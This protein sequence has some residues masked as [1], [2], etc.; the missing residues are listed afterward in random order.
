MECANRLKKL[1]K[2]L[3]YSRKR[4]ARLFGVSPDHYRK[5]ERGERHTSLLEV[6]ISALEFL[7]RK[8][9]LAKFERELEKRAKKSNTNEVDEENST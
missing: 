2:D 1:R 5:Y 6:H 8:R 3:G 7:K 4:M 9:L